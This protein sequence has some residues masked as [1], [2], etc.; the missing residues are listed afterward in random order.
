MIK[1]RQF[2]NCLHPMSAVN[3]LLVPVNCYVLVVLI[4]GP[5]QLAPDRIQ[6]LLFLIGAILYPL[7]QSAQHFSKSHRSAKMLAR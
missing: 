3:T 6:D 1:H 7:P 5:D 4:L 2:L